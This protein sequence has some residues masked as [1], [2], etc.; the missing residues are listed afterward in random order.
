MSLL[1]GLLILGSHYWQALAKV[2]PLMLPPSPGSFD[3]HREKAFWQNMV[4]I[5]C[6]NY[7]LYEVFF[8]RGEPVLWLHFKVVNL[9]V[10]NSSLRAAELLV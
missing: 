7:A 5:F 8:L 1:M 6:G 4:V 2:F 3:S 10:I 9:P